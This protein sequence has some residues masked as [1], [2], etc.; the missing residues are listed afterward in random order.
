RRQVNS[1]GNSI[2]YDKDLYEWGDDDWVTPYFEDMII[3]ELH[4]GSFSGEGDGVSASPARFRDAIDAHIDDLVE[5]GINMVEL[6]PVCE[7]AAER[8]W[9]YNPSFLFAIEEAYG[10]PDG[11]KYFVDH[12]HRRGIGVLID[13]VYNHLGGTD[14]A[15]NLLDY[16][17]EEIYFYPEGN[18][19]RDTP[20]GP[21]PDYGRREVREYIRDNIRFW[22]EEY[23]VDGFRLDG[24]AFVNV[25]AEGWQLLKEIA[26]VTDTVSRKA[27]VIAEH[28]P[29]DPAVT[30]PL[31]VGGAGIDSQ[32]ND[33]L[34][35]NLREA[36]HQAAFGD[37]NMASVAAGMNHFDLGTG[38]QV[39]NYIES[40][41]EAAV[42][43]RISVAADGN[44]PRSEYAIG[45]SKVALAIVVLSAGIPMLLQGQELLE[46]R[47]FGDAPEHRIR[48]SY[49]DTNDGFLGF[50]RELLA[51][52][53]RLPSF[54]SDGQQN[55]YHVNDGANVLA[56]HRYTND[57]HDA[58][59][60]VSLS[61]D[62]FT[63]YELGFPQGGV[64]YDVLNGS[65]DEFDGP[66]GSGRSTIDAG[67]PGRHGLPHSATIRVPRMAVRVFTQSPPPSEET[68][69]FLRG[70]CNGDGSMDLSDPVD[71]LAQLFLGGGPPDCES[72]CDANAD[73]NRDIS[74]A[75]Y[76]LS[77]LFLGGAPPPRPWPDCDVDP[78][79]DRDCP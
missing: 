58:V 4:V 68:G 54:R 69:G 60:V 55:V 72:A 45:R 39:V 56:W 70:D 22:L 51:L 31:A 65:R 78:S 46:S 77:Y 47:N 59:I 17:G 23:H 62:D 11:L 49:A 15:G 50:S 63:D 21:R 1:V 40:H 73:G 33:A 12:L 18:G 13:V 61:N 34:H 44:N 37:P 53:S 35:D 52:R 42:H 14:L 25:N 27:I 10:G 3:Y 75:V 57:G 5:L 2:V 29:N 26:E 32:W 30:R 8:S 48:W 41:D 79:C 43:G 24:T 20:W 64:W 38:T 9:G 76:S 71:G 36:I 28:L 16:D 66:G 67:G 74:D 19:F 6:M 7:F